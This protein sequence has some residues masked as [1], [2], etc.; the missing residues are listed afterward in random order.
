MQ[1]AVAVALTLLAAG[2]AR[3]DDVIKTG[4]WE[5][6]AE[7]Q[8]PNMP[9]PKLP[10]GLQLPPNI[11]AGPNGM[12]VTNTHCVTPDEAAPDVRPPGQ[13]NSKC[14]RDKWER[15]GGTVHW[16]M[17]CQTPRGPAHTEGVGHYHGDTM[18]ADVTTQTPLASG[19]PP[20]TVTTHIT[21]HYLGA[22]DA[23]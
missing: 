18:E 21:G 20:Q 11:Q 16:A 7:L 4:K 6:T 13:S 5:Y 1:F 14:T 23:K 19:A 10:P 8:M 3:A 15:G 12:K 22:C 9:M 2:L 17:T